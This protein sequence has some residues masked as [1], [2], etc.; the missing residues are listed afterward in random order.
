M[1]SIDELIIILNDIKEEHGNINVCKVG[2]YGE[3]HH[4]DQSDIGAQA[5]AEGVFGEGAEKMIVNIDTPDI[6]PE[7]D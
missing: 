5:A 7:P 6:G 3:I 1:L 4:L 2:H